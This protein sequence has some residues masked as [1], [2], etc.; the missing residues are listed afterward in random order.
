MMDLLILIP[1]VLQAFGFMAQRKGRIN[2]AITIYCLT[3]VLLW[4][5]IGIK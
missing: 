5:I 1:L 4:V 3:I 2:L